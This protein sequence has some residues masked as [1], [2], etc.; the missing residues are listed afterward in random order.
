[1]QPLNMLYNAVHAA[2]GSAAARLGNGI[3]IGNMV[4]IGEDSNKRSESPFRYE[5]R[6]VKIKR[7]RQRSSSSREP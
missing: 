1:M 4:Q 5:Y 7:T 2:D 6:S 3:R